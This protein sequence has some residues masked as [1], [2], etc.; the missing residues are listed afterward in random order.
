M[1]D[2]IRRT[3][4]RFKQDVPLKVRLERA[5]LQCRSAAAQSR[6]DQEQDALLKAARRYEAVA[7]LD[8][9][10][11]PPQPPR[12]VA[13]AKR[14]APRRRARAPSQEGRTASPK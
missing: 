14:A 5:A 9:L 3:R 11:C 4:K 12:P 7:D 2:K 6:S 13:Q 8:E 1:A 10:L